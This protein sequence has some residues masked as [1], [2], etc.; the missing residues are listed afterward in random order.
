MQ[1]QLKQDKNINRVKNNE[2][3]NSNMSKT[4]E[5]KDANST[6]MWQLRRRNH[7]IEN[8]QPKTL[9]KIRTHKNQQEKKLIKQLQI[10]SKIQKKVVILASN[11]S[12]WHC[13]LVALI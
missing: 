9:C 6:K 13:D 5:R 3:K 11:R 7:N 12:N 8:K 4:G 1:K 2:I 10:E